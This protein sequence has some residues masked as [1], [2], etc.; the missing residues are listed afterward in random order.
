MK[1]TSRRI[2]FWETALFIRHTERI[3]ASPLLSSGQDFDFSVVIVENVTIVCHSC[4]MENCKSNSGTR[5]ERKQDN[6]VY[7]FAFSLC[8]NPKGSR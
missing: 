4:C 2:E 3:A 1:L 8:K 7:F 6:A 5:S